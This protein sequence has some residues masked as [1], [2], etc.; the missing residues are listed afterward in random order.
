MHKPPDSPAGPTSVEDLISD[1]RHT[2][3]ALCRHANELARLDSL[4]AGCV[5]S[6]TASQFQVANLR[7]DRLV[8]LTPTAAWAT[9]L[10]MQAPQ[11]LLLLR[12][13]GFTNLQHVDIRV[14]PL[15]RP[16]AE[17]RSRRLLSPAAQQALAALRR[18]SRR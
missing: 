11:M 16:I 14:A 4:L 12:R 1:S 2:L 7:G 13:S 18:L 10:R 5:D 17:N 15:Q 9:R 3:G 6:D 8:L